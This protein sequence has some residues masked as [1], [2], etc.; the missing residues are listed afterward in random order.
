MDLCDTINTKNKPL[1]I[2]SE[3][4]LFPGSRGLDFVNKNFS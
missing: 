2:L 1:N 4:E 3:K